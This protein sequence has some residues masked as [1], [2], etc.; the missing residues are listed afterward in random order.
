MIGVKNEVRD[1]CLSAHLE[2]REKMEW[3]NIFFCLRRIGVGFEMR[4]WKEGWV[5][6]L[7]LKLGLG[8]VE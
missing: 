5:L 2:V 3:R 7:K 1:V 6:N 4:G 8:F